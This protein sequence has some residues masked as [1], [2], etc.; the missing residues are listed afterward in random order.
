M[1]IKEAQAIC[2]SIGF[3]L[4]KYDGEFQL[5]PIGF[6]SD[7]RWA[8]FTDDI[9]DAVETCRDMGKRAILFNLKP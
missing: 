6:N 1:T 5:Y 2:R 3:T 9:E 8:Y 4:R 7:H